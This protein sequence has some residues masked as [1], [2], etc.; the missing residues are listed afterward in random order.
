MHACFTKNVTI[1]LAQDMTRKIRALLH[2]SAV[3]LCVGCVLLDLT[4]E[5]C[6]CFA[7][8]TFAGFSVRGLGPGSGFG[9]LGSVVEVVCFGVGAVGLHA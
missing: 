3:G 5:D 7:F 9:L 4:L 1:C 6:T 2:N 8:R